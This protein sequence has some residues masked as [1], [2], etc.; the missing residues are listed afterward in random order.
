MSS[1]AAESKSILK[2]LNWPFKSLKPRSLVTSSKYS[3]E[4]S[5]VLVTIYNLREALNRS[6]LASTILYLAY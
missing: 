6:Q 3:G 5:I 2:V 4:L 1:R